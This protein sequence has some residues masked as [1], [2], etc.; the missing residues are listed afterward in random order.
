MNFVNEEDI[1][2]LQVGEHGGKITGALQHRS[3]GGL[4]PHL[5]LRGDD[6]G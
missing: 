6:I 1:A 2:G 5:H 3:R 4:E